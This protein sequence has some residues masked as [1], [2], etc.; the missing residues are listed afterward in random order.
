M[1]ITRP[2]NRVV[3]SNHRST[4]GSRRYE[5]CFKSNAV[6]FW[7]IHCS[8]I[9]LMRHRS[10][11]T[12]TAAAHSPY[13]SGTFVLPKACRGSP[14]S[15]S[16]PT[17]WLWFKRRRQSHSNNLR[18]TKDRHPEMGLTSCSQRPG[19][20]LYSRFSFGVFGVCNNFVMAAVYV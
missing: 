16:I 13:R 14:D 7:A 20:S 8:R 19:P 5:K 17:L 3:V 10:Q 1:I 6:G 9:I 4:A 15:I 18:K 2:S 11:S 12:S